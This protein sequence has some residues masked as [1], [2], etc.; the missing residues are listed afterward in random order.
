MLK[1]KCF[2]RLF[3]ETFLWQFVYIIISTNYYAN[4]YQHFQ[5]TFQHEKFVEIQRNL[6]FYHIIRNPQVEFCC[7]LETIY[8][9][10]NTS[11]VKRLK[12]FAADYDMVKKFYVEQRKRLLDELGAVLIL[13]GR[14]GR[15]ARMV[16]GYYHADGIAFK[17]CLY[18]HSHADLGGVYYAAAY[19]LARDYAVCGAQ[20]QRIGHLVCLIHELGDKVAP[21]SVA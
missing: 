11:F 10:H 7:K 2:Q 18:E 17:R 19:L 5:H 6:S 20:K 8:R 16:V 13:F 3:V 1:I 4:S 21:R 14:N 15:R 12:L 9:L